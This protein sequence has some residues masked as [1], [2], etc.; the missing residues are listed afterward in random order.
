MHLFQIITHFYINQ[1]E[2]WGKMKAV[3]CPFEIFIKYSL[4]C[5]KKAK[6]SLI[7][8][9]SITF[10]AQHKLSICKRLQIETVRFTQIKTVWKVLKL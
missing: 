6:I 10:I 8:Q 9:F 1:S 5:K 2:Q 7:L 4:Q 3:S